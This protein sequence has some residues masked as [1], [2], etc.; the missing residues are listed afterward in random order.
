[1]TLPPDSLHTWEDIFHRFNGKY[2]S[3][4]KTTALRQ[5]IA[6][7]AQQEGELLHEAWE[8]FKQLQMECSH[9]HYSVELLNQFFYDGLNV[10]NQCM[11][12]SAAGGTV[13]VKT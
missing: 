7:F 4:Q 10:Q 8:R 6:T 12:D 2:Y 3:H 5:K 13:G 9:H 1:M 11:M